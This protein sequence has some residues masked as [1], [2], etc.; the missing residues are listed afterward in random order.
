MKWFISILG[1]VIVIALMNFR[2]QVYSEEQQFK[3]GIT[4]KI[5]LFVADGCDQYK[6]QN[7]KWPDSLEKLR[8]FRAG[9]NNS[10]TQDGWGRDLTIVPFNSSLGY[11]EVVSY[12]R[13]GKPGGTGLNKDLSVRFP[14]APNKG[15]NE[16]AGIGLQLP[17]RV[18]DTNWFEENASSL[19][20]YW[21]LSPTN[22]GQ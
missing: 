6:L 9:F 11:G 7:G 16:H 19:H 21:S 3:A 20:S 4:Y 15:W 18:I 14:T 13:D 17:G 22:S 1:V 2:F 10:D 12:G 8:G 5:L